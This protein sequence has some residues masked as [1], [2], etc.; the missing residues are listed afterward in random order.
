MAVSTVRDLIVALEDLV[1]ADPTSLDREL[2]LEGCDC[3][4]DFSGTVRTLYDD[5]VLVERL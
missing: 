5:S 4:G 1:D 3:Y 2:Q